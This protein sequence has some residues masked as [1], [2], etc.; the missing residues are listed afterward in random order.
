MC[1]L[2]SAQ[3]FEEGPRPM[4]WASDDAVFRDQDIFLWPSVLQLLDNLTVVVSPLGNSRVLHVLPGEATI[5]LNS[6]FQT[7]YC[8]NLH[9]FDKLSGFFL[10]V[11]LLQ[12]DSRGIERKGFQRDTRITMMSRNKR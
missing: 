3:S 8:G 10:L 11:F 4:F 2:Y 9:I 12:R 5:F 6:F 7:T 1:F